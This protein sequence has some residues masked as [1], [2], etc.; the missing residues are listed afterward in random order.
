[1]ENFTSLDRI[2]SVGFPSPGVKPKSATVHKVEVARIVQ[3]L[4]WE[5][6]SREEVNGNVF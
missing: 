3:T 6:V 5:L 1:M 4:R 2:L